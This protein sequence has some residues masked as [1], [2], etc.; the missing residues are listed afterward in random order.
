MTSMK[1]ILDMWLFN[2]RFL[3]LLACFGGTS[4]LLAQQDPMFSQYQ[5]N[6]LSINPAYA[7]AK[8]G[9][10]GVLLHRN[11][12]TKISGSPKTN[13]FT[14]HSPVL[15]D[16]VG[17][18]LNVVQDRI[19]V[20]ARTNL[21]GAVNYR[22]ALGNKVLSAGLQIGFTQYRNNW[23]DINTGNDNQKDPVFA[24]NETFSLPNVGLGVYLQAVKYF[25]G[26]S[27]PYALNH[28][29]NENI[30]SSQ[31]RQ[32]RHVFANA[33]YL[34][35][36]NKSILFKPSVLLKYV[37]GAPLQADLNASFVLKER[38]VPGVSYRTNDGISI[39][40]QMNLIRELWMGYA[41][42]FP[43]SELR[44]HTNGSHEIFIS[45]TYR[46]KKPKVFSPRY[47]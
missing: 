20:S 9:V 35:E 18:G 39:M 1:N 13:T 8:G 17:L 22:L 34:F 11:Q 19:G 27:I 42:D 28:Q 29:F 37:Q 16:K 14:L 15:D 24:G 46:I 40:F 10:F 6:K 25:V 12:W 4:K 44:R 31:A 36:V 21:Y 47:F 41:F 38:F 45:Y 3:M 30:K 43:F 2:V 7:G 32:F 33:G 5:Y 23:N 26:F